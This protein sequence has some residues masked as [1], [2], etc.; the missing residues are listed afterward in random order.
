MLIPGTLLVVTGVRY[1]G[2]VSPSPHLLTYRG[3]SPLSR[4]CKYRCPSL[5]HI[6]KIIV[7]FTPCDNT[8][9]A[10]LAHRWRQQGHALILPSQ[11]EA[12]IFPDGKFAVG[13]ALPSTGS[14]VSECVHFCVLACDCGML[15]ERWAAPPDVETPLSEGEGACHADSSQFAGELCAYREWEWEAEVN[16]CSEDAEAREAS[17][18]AINDNTSGILS[19]RTHSC[20]IVPIA[21]PPPII[22]STLDQHPRPESP[23]L[24]PLPLEDSRLYLR[25]A[26]DIDSLPNSPLRG[27]SIVNYWSTSSA[28]DYSSSNYPSPT[29]TQSPLHYTQ[30][31]PRASRHMLYSP[32]G[33]PVACSLTA[34]HSIRSIGSVYGHVPPAILVHPSQQVQYACPAE[35]SQ[36]FHTGAHQFKQ[37]HEQVHA[38]EDS[39]NQPSPSPPPSSHHSPQMLYTPWREQQPACIYAPS[40]HQVHHGYPANYDAAPIPQHAL[41]SLQIVWC[42]DGYVA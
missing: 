17:A 3:I 16:M 33:I 9:P 40:G 18:C 23:P 27:H 13:A 5:T 6:P 34:R 25:G 14:T 39:Q 41:S 22:P 2:V 31:H 20:T 36:T 35:W 21:L 7:K 38:R 1:A 12:A 30:A 42:W 26:M 24:S 28:S 19:G 10:T 4:L 15:S 11:R 29:A 32:A 8:P 37:E